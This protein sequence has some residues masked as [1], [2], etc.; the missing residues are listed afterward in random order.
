[1]LPL[2]GQS[3]SAAYRL[4][5]W[6]LSLSLTPASAYSTCLNSRFLSPKVS[7]FASSRG[8]L[9]ILFADLSLE[10]YNSTP[11]SKPISIP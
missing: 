8:M 9:P 10:Q 2:L 7:S 1:M 6:A 3:A 4:T 11:Q 5:G